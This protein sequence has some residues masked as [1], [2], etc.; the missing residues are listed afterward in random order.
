MP[1]QLYDLGVR[2]MLLNP[3]KGDEDM[4]YWESLCRVKATS[5]GTGVMALIPQ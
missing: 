3:D 4:S 1:I 5:Y 2:S